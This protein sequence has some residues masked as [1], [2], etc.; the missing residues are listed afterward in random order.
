MPK[1]K[2]LLNAFSPKAAAEVVELSVHMLN[3]LARQGYLIPT[4]GG[5][6]RRGRVR[7]Y[8]F[9]DLVVARL[10]KRL[11]DGGLEISRLKNGISKLTHEPRWTAATPEKQLRMLATDG[12]SLFFVD[13]DGAIADLTRNGQLAF[14]FVLDVAVAQ[15]EVRDRLTQDQLNHYSL[16]NLKL[17][18][19]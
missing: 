2:N 10:V 8:S 6:G 17:K 18:R 14:A 12:V 16:R 1:A 15:A 19:A 11:L 3:Y 5:D 9:R 4:Y 7:Y 13:S